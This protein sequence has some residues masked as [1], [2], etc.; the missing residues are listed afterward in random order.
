MLARVAKNDYDNENGKTFT[1]LDRQSYLPIVDAHCH[2]FGQSLSVG[3]K[4]RDDSDATHVTFIKGG[5]GGSVKKLFKPTVLIKK[6]PTQVQS[7]VGDAKSLADKAPPGLMDKAKGAASSFLSSAG[8]AMPSVKKEDLEKAQSVAKEFADRQIGEVLQKVYARGVIELPP[9]EWPPQATTTLV[10]DRV[11]FVVMLSERAKIHSYGIGSEKADLTEIAWLVGHMEAGFAKFIKYFFGDDGE[12]AGIVLNGV[13]KEGGTAV[14]PLLLDMGYTPLD[15]PLPLL[16]TLA[17]WLVGL[18]KPAPDPDGYYKAGKEF[19]WFDRKGLQYTYETLADVAS[20]YPYQIWPMVPF[21]PRR[22]DALSH[23]KKAVNEFAFPGVKLYSRCGWAPYNNADVHGPTHGPKLDQRLDAFYAYAVQEDLPVLNHTSPTGFPPNAALALPKGYDGADMYHS[24]LLYPGRVGIGPLPLGA[25]EG[26]LKDVGQGMLDVA[27]LPPPE[28]LL[29]QAKATG[30]KMLQ[31]VGDLANQA[32]DLSQEHFDS[33]VSALDKARAKGPAEIER[34]TS[35]ADPSK[36]S[37]QAVRDQ[38]SEYIAPETLSKIAD[39]FNPKQFFGLASC[40]KGPDFHPVKNMIDPQKQKENAAIN[41]EQRRSPLKVL[42]DACCKILALMSCYDAA[43]YCHYVQHTVSP[44]AWEPVLKKYPK[45]RL[46]LAH[47]GSEKSVITHYGLDKDEH[48][49]GKNPTAA[50]KKTCD[51]LK[52]QIKDLHA[53]PFVA[54]GARFKDYLFAQCAKE[55]GI[56][57]LFQYFVTSEATIDPAKK[58]ADKVTEMLMK[59]LPAVFAKVLKQFTLQQIYDGVRVQ[60]PEVLKEELWQQWLEDWADKFPKDWIT[61]IKELCGKYDNVY[62]DI[63]YLTGTSNDVHKLLLAKIADDACPDTHRREGSD[64][65]VEDESTDGSTKE[66]IFAERLMIGTDWYMTAMDN[67]GPD[68]FWER[69]KSVVNT[70]HPL[71]ERWAS[72]N[73][74]NFMNLG[75]RMDAMEKWYKTR[76][77]PDSSRPSWWP[78]VKHYYKVKEEKGAA[79]AA[80]V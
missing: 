1:P 75:K 3:D 58:A 65:G 28:E 48:E 18:P 35:L 20:Q 14:V 70:D 15:V 6:P 66:T 45:L 17:A 54:T 41:A 30:S 29:K 23:V 55:R 68:T 51:V 57:A 37:V 25:L 9:S 36:L 26:I 59:V 77:I 8:K 61:K 13:P 46:D 80:K 12:N 71:W 19:L 62:T 33:L 78:A 56:I 40:I 53:N 64:A 63:S 43:K 11:F 10:G 50:A 24:R 7:L 76:N 60:V 79:A 16:G 2:V 32:K 72:R 42:F 31:D 73:C 44:Y 38:L 52:D 22:P 47:C 49:I 34:L 74:I 27:G 4:I 67:V 5:S 39:K 21:D 69:T